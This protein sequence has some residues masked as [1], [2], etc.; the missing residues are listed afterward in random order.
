MGL[1]YIWMLL[2][3]LFTALFPGNWK[4]TMA[5]LGDIEKGASVDDSYFAVTTVTAALLKKNIIPIILR[6]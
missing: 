1:T 3:W 2:E 5:D 6:R 4:H